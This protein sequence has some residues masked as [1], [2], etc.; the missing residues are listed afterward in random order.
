LKV[1]CCQQPFAR[2]EY[3]SVAGGR[4]STSAPAILRK[5][6]IILVTSVFFRTDPAFWEYSTL[7]EHKGLLE[8][9]T[10]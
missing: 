3:S 4:Q 7:D 9:L 8:I 2:R 10:A 1:N 5:F 6:R